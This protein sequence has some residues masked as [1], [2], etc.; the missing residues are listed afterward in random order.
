M[1]TD[2]VCGDEV[3]G[4]CPALRRYLEEHA[5]GYVLRVAKTFLLTLGGGRSLSCADV[6]TTHLRA[7]QRWMIA[8]AGTGSKAERGY[9]WASIA[10]ASP[11]HSL[12]IPPPP[13]P[14]PPPSRP[15][16]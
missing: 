8:S 4:S 14:A 1:V 10:P 15:F 5:Q 3:Y 12:P 2:F 9:A 13:P 7:R 6:V 11:R 16:P